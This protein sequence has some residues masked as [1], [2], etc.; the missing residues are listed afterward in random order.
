VTHKPL[1][2]TANGPSQKSAATGHH[3]KYKL[4]IARQPRSAYTAMNGQVGNR[5]YALW[6]SPAMN[7]QIFLKSANRQ[8]KSLC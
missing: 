8:K 1:W 3:S 2:L 7:A 5:I 6:A 4:Q